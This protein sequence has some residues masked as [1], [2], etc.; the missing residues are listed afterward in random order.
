MTAAEVAKMA[1]A[2]AIRT[3]RIRALVLERFEVTKTM[4][5]KVRVSEV[6]EYVAE[7]MGRHVFSPEFRRS[8]RSAVE[9]MGVR[10]SNAKN[11]RRW[12]GMRR[13]A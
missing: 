6:Q 1:L 4:S 13:K 7:R 11:I 8:V 12:H 10:E 2:Q 9:T 5:D 3:M